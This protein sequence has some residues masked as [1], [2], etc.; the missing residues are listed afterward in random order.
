MDKLKVVWICHFSNQEI[1]DILKPSKRVAEIA[2]WINHLIKRF[3][4][5]HDVEL[6]IV[7][8]HANIGADQQFEL[9]GI[10]YHIFSATL[11][12]GGISFRGFNRCLV[13]FNWIFRFYFS[14]AIIRRIVTSINPDI[15]HLHGAENAY[16][17]SSILQFEKKYPILITIQGFI[18]HSTQRDFATRLRIKYE[19]KIIKTFRHFGYRTR[20]MGNDIRKINPN[21]ILHWHHYPVKS[22]TP[23][24]AVKKYDVVFFARIDKDK[25]IEDLLRAIAIIKKDKPDIKVCVIGGGYVARLKKQYPELSES[26]TWAGC[27]QEQADVHQ[28]AASAR[29]SVLPTYHD[30]IP[31]TIIESMFLKLPVIAYDVG[32]IHE[33]NDHDESV[34]LVNKGDVEG[35]AKAIMMLLSD[36]TSQKDKAEK[37]YIRIGEMFDNSTVF[38]DLCRAYR[39]VV[40]SFRSKAKTGG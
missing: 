2:P 9:R 8:P 16:Y 10:T 19:Q 37:G 5:Q 38:G 15:I 3:E 27:L 6:H 36:E 39:E 25:G 29:I 4:D 7:A 13:W 32:S 31:G 35:L 12:F 28:L 26:V 23:I 11:P 18:S 30:I 22:I 24:A 21:A 40:S 17:S 1:Q 34:T 14:K 33:I 20:T